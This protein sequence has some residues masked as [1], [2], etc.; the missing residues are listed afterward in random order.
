MKCV[1]F[2]CIKSCKSYFS[3]KV[4]IFNNANVKFGASSTYTKVLIK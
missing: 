2:G 3:F 4:L 1:V